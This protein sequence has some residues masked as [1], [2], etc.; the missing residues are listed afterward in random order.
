MTNFIVIVSVKTC[1]DRNVVNLNFLCMGCRHLDSHQEN[2]L[3]RTAIMLFFMM[4]LGH[5]RYN[6]NVSRNIISKITKTKH[7][8]ITII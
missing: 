6:Y 3:L 5:K 1:W 2:K 7:S 8:T 4:E